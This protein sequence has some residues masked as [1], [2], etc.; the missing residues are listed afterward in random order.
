M[1]SKVFFHNARASAKR[2]RIHKVRELFYKA[3]LEKLIKEGDRVAIKVH[4]G[5]P[6][7]V[8]FIPPRYVGAIVELVQKSGGLPY[9]TD[10]NTLY[11][12]MRRNAVQNI[13]AAA[14]NGFTALTLGAPL[15]VA[16]GISG[17]DYRDIELPG[18]TVGKAKIAS[19][20]IDADAMIVLSHV[21]GHMLFGFGGALKNLGMGCATPAG[22]QIL[23]SDLRP[24]VDHMKCT[25]DGICS[26]RCPQQ[27][28]ENL[29]GSA[30]GPD[31]YLTLYW[32][33][34]VHGRVP[35]RSDSNPLDYLGRRHSNQ[36]RR[37]R[38][39]CG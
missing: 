4:W 27:C 20:I 2:N 6:G 33:R 32:L 37:I 23:H 7:N 34:R 16:D 13:L 17:R 29:K 26:K 31:R 36:N 12:G 35:P 8:A 1:E 25:G 19:G 18:S 5:E 38:D 11:T 14:Q 39:G 21:K 10:T 9:V 22:K 28:I 15:I 3:G 30:N 24:S